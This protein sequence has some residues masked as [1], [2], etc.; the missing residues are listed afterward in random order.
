MCVHAKLPQLCLTLCDPID[1]RLAGSS[2]HG[3][4][5][6]RILE[7]V[8]ISFSRGGLP[9]PGIEPES[10]MSPALAGGCF[11]T[12]A[13]W[14]ASHHS[15]MKISFFPGISLKIFSPWN[16]HS[17][18]SQVSSWKHGFQASPASHTPVTCRELEAPLSLRG[19][20]GLLPDT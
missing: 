5:W 11:T 12:S 3:I 13:T 15:D 2:V 8:A 6:A 19:L 4:L 18:N 16:S 20:E 7:S 10:L 14:E 9:D 17:S 1:C